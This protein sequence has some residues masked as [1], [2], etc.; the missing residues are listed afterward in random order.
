L[1]YIGPYLKSKT[2]LPIFGVSI[3]EYFSWQSKAFPGIEVPFIL[4]IVSKR[5]VASGAFEET[6]IFRLPGDFEQIETLKDKFQEGDFEIETKDPHVLA[7]LFKLWLRE[8][9][10]PLVPKSMYVECLKIAD[11]RDKCIEML[12]KLPQLNLSVVIFVIQ[13]LSSILTDEFFQKTKMDTENI[14]V[15]FTPNFIRNDEITN[16]KD[17]MQNAPR[18]K[19]FVKNL[20]LS[21]KNPQ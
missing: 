7:S 16:P 12:M 15:V 5:L 11:D 20:I 18:E 8:L 14:A 21:A 10:G 2:P 9:S 4:D 13:F 6:G 19:L 1:K 3:E 17:I